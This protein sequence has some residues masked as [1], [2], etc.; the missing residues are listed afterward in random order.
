MRGRRAAARS[1]APA[2]TW[3]R[4]GTRARDDVNGRLEERLRVVERDLLGILAEADESGTAVGRI[5]HDRG[6]LRQRGDDLFGVGDTVPVTGDR[7]E[8]VVNRRA[9]G[10]EMLHLLQHRIGSAVREDIAGQ[11]EDRQPV[12]VSHGGGGHHVGGARPDGRS[13]DHDLAAAAGPGEA[14]RGER[15]RLFVLAAPGRQLFLHRLQGLREA[16]HVAVAEDTEHP[17][18]EPFPAGPGLHPL[19]A[20]VA[21]EGLGHRESHRLRRHLPTP[22]RFLRSSGRTGGH[23][24]RAGRLGPGRPL[25]PARPR[26]PP[27][28]A[29]RRPGRAW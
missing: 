5:E 6:R 7:A 10:V 26:R 15:H 25:H 3:L 24:F 11:D 16:G 12:R 29:G 21:N 8:R 18:K 20:Q 9:G 22:V 19:T 4:S 28:A 27:A 23:P 1:A 13:R 2:A 17:R 14:E